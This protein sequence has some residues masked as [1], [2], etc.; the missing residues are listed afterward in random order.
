[1]WNDEASCWQQL[2]KHTVVATNFPIPPRSQG[3][4]LEIS[5]ADMTLL[6]RSLNLVEYDMG[7]VAEGL[8]TLL[9]PV[10][11]L[12]EDD[13][14]Q[15]HLE[16]KF[17]TS[18]NEKSRKLHASRILRQY[19]FMNWYRDLNS[20]RLQGRRCFLGWAG[21]VGVEVG[22]AKLSNKC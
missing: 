17:Q 15:W 2:F 11:E 21:S 10:K 1:M 8:R 5:F 12:K 7:L 13:A 6:A 4:G 22:T 20:K 14:V 3:M 9:I 18:S 16:E 19:E